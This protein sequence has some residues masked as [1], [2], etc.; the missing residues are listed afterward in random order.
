LTALPVA[1]IGVVATLLLMP[2]DGVVGRVRRGLL[3]LRFSLRTLVT[4]RTWGTG[5]RRLTSPAC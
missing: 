5:R 1:M 2:A 4:T 3:L